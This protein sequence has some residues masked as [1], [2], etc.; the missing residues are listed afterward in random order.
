MTWLPSE[1]WV[2]EGTIGYLD[3]Q[4]DELKEFSVVSTGVEEGNRLPYTPELTYSLGIGYSSVTAGGWLIAPRVD[5]SYRDDT[6]WDANNTEE[7]AV[8]SD[9]SI[10]NAAIVLG[11]DAGPWRL[12]LAVKNATDEE[13]S[14][15]GNSSL[16]TGSGYAEI[17]YARPRQYYATFE[18]DF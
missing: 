9:Y 8:N 14:T 6:Y 13:Y 7:I 16:S 18:Y 10:I 17:A 5:L 4:I 15:G 11:P 3:A 12:R 2:I 1:A